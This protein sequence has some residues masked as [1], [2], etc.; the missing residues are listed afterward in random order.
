LQIHIH[1]DGKNYGP[2]TL[3]QV[4]QYLKAGN[5]SGNDP[6]CHDGANWIKLSQITGVTPTK[7]QS[8][9]KP[10]AQP[11]RVETKP[12]KKLLGINLLIVGFFL[13]LVI[14]LAGLAYY[15]LGG[16]KEKE[17]T[18]P[19]ASDEN[20]FILSPDQIVS[21][22]DGDTFKID[23]P[24]LHPLFGDALSIRLFGVD[25]PEMRGT[26][27]EVKALAM[28]AQKVTRKAL[29][30]A[31]KIELRNP[32]RGKYFR[33]VSEVWIDGESLADMLRASGLAKDYDGEGARP[34]W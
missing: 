33:I 6:A 32:Q 22:Y 26:T 16:D 8:I 21:V 2:F 12:A 9:A 23:L 29:A 34:K 20:V 10:V 24:S 4:Y 7:S 11:A 25:T 31:S 5:F 13:A 17:E 18:A 19:V 15:L 27:E 1:K 3:E 30:E 14:S 28:K